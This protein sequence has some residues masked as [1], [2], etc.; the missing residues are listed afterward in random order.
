MAALGPIVTDPELLK[1]LGTP[2]P[3]DTSSGSQ[4]VL[5]DVVTDP[6]ILEQLNGPRSASDAA[7]SYAKSAASGVGEGVS[8]FAGLPVD[9]YNTV[10]DAFFGRLPAYLADKVGMHDAAN[11][12]RENGY[13]DIYPGSGQAIVDMQNQAGLDHQPQTPGE[14]DVKNA[15]SGATTGALSLLAT[16]GL[17]S[18]AADT[19]AM[20]PTALER[21]TALG[22][23]AAAPTAEAL[24]M[25]AAKGAL[26]GAGAATGADAASTLNK[27]VL[28]PGWQLPDDFVR[29]LGSMGGGFGTGIG[30]NRT[31][32]YEKPPIMNDFET[33]GVQPHFASDLN[34]NPGVVGK[35][36]SNT[37][38]KRFG[39]AGISSNN[40]QATQDQLANYAKQFLEPGSMT[41]QQAGNRI[42]TAAQDS[43][44]ALNDSTNLAFQRLNE[45]VD[46]KVT[47]PLTNTKA[48]VGDLVNRAGDPDLK[49]MV[50]NPT[51]E[52][53]AP[54]LNKD[55]MTWSDMDVLR[56]AVGRAMQ[57]AQGNDVGLLKQ[58]YRGVMTDLREASRANPEW[59]SLYAN[60]AKTAEQNNDQIEG[61]LGFVN[62]RES[63]ETLP[64]WLTAQ[65]KKGGTR[66]ETLLNSPGF[67]VPADPDFEDNFWN[68]AYG[69]QDLR[70]LPLAQHEIGKY[71]L[72][73]KAQNGDFDLNRLMKFWQQASPEARQQ[74]TLDP[75]VAD[76]M[77]RLERLYGAT[78]HSRSLIG[79][80]AKTILND[81]FEMATE[82]LGGL[83]ALHHLGA[84]NIG[85][86]AAATYFASA[87]LQ[88]WAAAKVGQIPSVV[89]RLAAPVAGNMMTKGQ[90]ALPTAAQAFPEVYQPDFSSHDNVTH[91]A[92][93]LGQAD[94]QTAAAYVG[95]RLGPQAAQQLA[96]AKGTAYKA[97]LFQLM[98]NPQSRQA[99]FSSNGG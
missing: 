50:Q 43:I 31:A 79:Q 55:N 78:A 90:M 75:Q 92:E 18:L 86:G 2:A 4:P 33:A 48:A 77:A 37:L 32:L 72:A 66:L 13:H 47:V 96:S 49:A 57:G 9:L 95:Q 26:T 41:M 68:G 11:W 83:T 91:N 63:P 89:S 38:P 12:V 52:R 45:V 56:Q 87:P 30:M 28:A 71:L 34:P 60:A 40:A 10:G 98:S 14:A 62:N 67:K 51:F 97:A 5:G 7:A 93:W 65:A 36:F 54:L 17:G 23:G 82:G 58:L 74:L 69:G 1:E 15:L 73:S 6:A 99:L 27:D 85:P 16:G 29:F 46:P 8:R 80:G 81:P 94:P 88:A 42:Q 61:I 20:A 59:E 39:A 22:T 44:D 84:G 3:V 25:L 64:D 53:F 76:G 35:V 70:N 24:P 19:G 21:G